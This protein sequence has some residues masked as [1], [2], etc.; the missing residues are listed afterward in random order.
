ML[1]HLHSVKQRPGDG[2]AHVGGAEEEHLREKP[3]A[4]TFAVGVP[5]RT[6]KGLLA[7]A[8]RRIGLLATS[9]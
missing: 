5:G 7:Y 2:V 1:S 8:L 4:L 9:E 6:L 3:S